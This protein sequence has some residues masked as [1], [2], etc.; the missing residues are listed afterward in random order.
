MMLL[1]KKYHNMEHA[2][3]EVMVMDG[4]MSDPKVQSSIPNTGSDFCD[5]FFIKN[6]LSYPR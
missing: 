4:W 2:G 3:V 6:E 5:F 1:Q